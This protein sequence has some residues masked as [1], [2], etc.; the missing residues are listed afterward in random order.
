MPI[1]KTL[2][3]SFFFIEHLILGGFRHFGVRG[4]DQVVVFYGADTLLPSEGRMFLRGNEVDQREA[5]L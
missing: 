3:K 2:I 4:P 1:R 5:D